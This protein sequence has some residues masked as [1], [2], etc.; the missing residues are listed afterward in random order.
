MRTSLASR[1]KHSLV[2]WVRR[3]STACLKPENAL[4]LQQA[5]HFVRHYSET[6]ATEQTFIGRLAMFDAIF[7]NQL[8][9]LMRYVLY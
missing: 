6:R 2:T 7:A 8:S 1:C 3:F 5:A 4:S 9:V